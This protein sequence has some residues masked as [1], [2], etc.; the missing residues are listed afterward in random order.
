MIQDMRYFDSE[1]CLL[2]PQEMGRADAMTVASGT[3]EI[4]LMGN[5]GREVGRFIVDHFRRVP[6]SILCGPGNNG[7]DGFAIG[8]FLRDR[9]WPVR[10]VQFGDAQEYSKAAK[11]YLERWGEPEPFSAQIIEDAGLLIDALFGA[12]LGRAI[13]GDYLD[14]VRLANQSRIPIVAVDMPTGVLGDT[15]QVLGEA[16]KA[17]ATVTFFRKKPGHLLMPG[18]EHCGDVALAQ[19]GISD[20]VLAEIKPRAAQNSPALW[21]IPTQNLAGHKYSKGHCVVVSGPTGATGAA[22]MCALAALRIGAGLVTINGDRAALAEHSA[23]LSAIM[24]REGDLAQLLED[25]RYNALVVGPGN[26][27]GEATY[28]NVLT[29]LAASRALLLDADA[30]TIFQSDPNELF[31]TIKSSDSD[32]VLTPHGGELVRLFPDLDVR[33]DK[34]GAARKAAQISGAVVVLKGADTIISEPN[35]R[36]VINANAP[37]WLATAGSGDFLAGIIGGLQ[38]QG[39][40]AFDAACAGVYV[41]GLAATQFGGAGMIATDLPQL[42]PSALVQAR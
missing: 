4:E 26:G 12:G 1:H 39:M 36:V 22:R 9:G 42:L 37:A 28:H 41:H 17:D 33:T 7:G 10:L 19:I 3:N 34:V 24:L 6:V 27:V 35:G 31:N 5:A 20:Q 11:F 15:G 25:K 18:R 8:C 23:H 16:I 38:A 29:G 14:V 40:E 30:L 2:T 32:V 13:E 21:T